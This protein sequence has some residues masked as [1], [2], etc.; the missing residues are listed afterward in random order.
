MIKEHTTINELLDRLYRNPLCSDVTRELVIDYLLDFYRITGVPSMYDEKVFRSPLKNYRCKLPCD[1]VEE[2][3]VLLKDRV[4]NT[5]IPARASTD[6]F[7]QQPGK[8]TDHAFV[9]N[10]MYLVASIESGEVMVSYR[11]M[12][13]DEQGL[14]AL[15]ADRLFLS[16]LESYVKMNY[17]QILWENGRIPDK[18]FQQA[19]QDYAWNVGKLTSTGRVPTLSEMENLKNILTSLIPGDNEFER[20]FRGTGRYNQVKQLHNDIEK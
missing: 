5:F 11:A 12:I 16:A 13:L 9:I 19:Q 14:P 3:Q 15:P 1:F 2:I 10:N 4:A 18:P 20:R 8:T 17:Y 6:A 7:R